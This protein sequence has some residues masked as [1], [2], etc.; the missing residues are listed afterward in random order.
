METS[1]TVP[2]LVWPGW[3]P[4]GCCVDALLCL[5]VIINWAPTV[6]QTLSY[7]LA[8]SRSF[9]QGLRLIPVLSGEGTVHLERD[10]NNPS[11]LFPRLDSSEFISQ[12]RVFCCL[13]LRFMMMED[14]FFP[15][16]SSSIK[17]LPRRCVPR[18]VDRRLE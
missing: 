6:C 2:H 15:P 12:E 9:E 11:P 8:P 1:F 4:Q 3:G 10:Y 7:T 5:Y 16:S 13:I 14:S 17:C 18:M